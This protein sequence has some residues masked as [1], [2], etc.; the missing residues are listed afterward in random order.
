MTT[1]EENIYRLVPHEAPKRSKDPS[2]ISKFRNS[3]SKEDQIK[4]KKYEHRTMG[5]PHYEAD[6]HNFLKKQHRDEL[7][8]KKT[9]EVKE[10]YGV[11]VGIGIDTTSASQNG[12]GSQKKPHVPTQEE[13]PVMGLKTT[14]N[15]ITQNAVETI[16]SVPKKPQKYN[17]DTRKGDKFPLEPS[18]L[19]PIYIKKKEYGQVPEYL[20][21]R[22][23]EIAQAQHEY[24]AYIS[25]MQKR[26]EMYQISP[27]ERQV[28][29]E[30][31]KK[32]WEEFYHQYQSLPMVV[33]TVPKKNRKEYLEN[34]MKKLERDIETIEKHKFIF[35]AN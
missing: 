29:L 17:V 32:N 1:M 28:I 14:K 33:D 23:S 18:G 26:G 15:F 35:I 12:S 20:I 11:G 31:L 30:G 34:E 5:E 8:S 3:K 6:P 22:R 7:E 9:A 2:Y 27:E 19:E 4:E 25:E 13:R 24:D 16:M 10:L 21:K